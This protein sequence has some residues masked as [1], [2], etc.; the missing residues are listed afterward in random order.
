MASEKFRVNLYMP[1]LMVDEI[2]SIAE[3]LGGNRTSLINFVL[4]KYLDDRNT[5]EYAELL[6]KLQNGELKLVKSE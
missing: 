5:L 6:M 4:K 3:E 2:D 1:K